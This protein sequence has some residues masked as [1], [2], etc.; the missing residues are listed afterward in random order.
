MKGRRKQTYERGRPGREPEPAVLIVTEGE[1]TEPKYFEGLRSALR[2]AATSV[3]VVKAPGTDP[4][5]IVKHGIDKHLA[6][7]KEA[8]RGAGVAYEEVWAVFDS[9]QRLGT[10]QLHRAL[11]LARREGIHVAMSSPCFEYWLILHYEYTTRYMCSYD[12]VVAR[13]KTH[14][15]EYD[16]SYPPVS[17]LLSRL[18]AAVHNA[19]LC[20]GAQDKADAQLPRTD[21]DLLAV[22]L[23]SAAREHNRIM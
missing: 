14:V 15:P 13:L 22:R 4:G 9:E 1:K 7:M 12:E 10:E 2:L 21:V 16:K 18:P 3:E 23:N 20:R 8:K 19:Q 6:R 5:T 17:E 11:D